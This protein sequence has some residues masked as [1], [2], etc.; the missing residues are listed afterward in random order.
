MVRNNTEF[1]YSEFSCR[2]LSASSVSLSLRCVDMLLVMGVVVVVLPEVD[3]EARAACGERYV[4]TPHSG[5]STLGPTITDI[6]CTYESSPRRHLSRQRHN[7]K[8][9]NT[10]TRKMDGEL[11]IL[12]QCGP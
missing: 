3:D 8:T 1:D 10:S 4:L 6:A 11:E 2:A 9:T 12:P 5:A 7:S